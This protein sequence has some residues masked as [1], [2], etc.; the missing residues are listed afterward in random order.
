MSKSQPVFPPIEASTIARSVVGTNSTCAPRLKRDAAN[1]VKSQITPPPIPTKR[2]FLAKPASTAV[3]TIVRTLS[4]FLY[5]SP[6]P[7]IISSSFSHLPSVKFFIK[8]TMHGSVATVAS[9]TKHRL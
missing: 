8:S 7:K 2:S 9:V 3:F 6:E 1:P 5:A 4:M